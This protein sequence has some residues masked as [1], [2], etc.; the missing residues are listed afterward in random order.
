MYSDYKLAAFRVLNPVRRAKITA[1]ISLGIALLL[2]LGAFGDEVTIPNTPLPPD[3]LLEFDL[4]RDYLSGKLESWAR[5]LDRFFGDYR[6]YQESNESVIQFDFFRVM[7]YEDKP[8]FS[9]ATNIKVSLPNTE[10][11][12]QFLIETNPDT[13]TAAGPTKIQPQ[14]TVKKTTPES[15]SAALRYERIEAERWHFTTDGGIQLAG[16]N[17]TPFVRARL[18]LAMPLAQWNMKIADSVFWFSTIGAGESTLIDFERPIN[19]ALMFRASSNA[20]WLNDSQNFDL[21]QDMSFFH[22]LNERTA[23]LYQMSAIGMSNPQTQVSDY[24]ILMLYRYRLHREWMFI[25]ISPQMHYPIA[26]DFQPSPLLSLRL[27]ILFDHS[28]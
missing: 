14:P 10:K 1:C 22:A 4:P 23:V 9:Y 25:E 24:V 16:L 2:P 13:N 27:E 26:R 6:N 5:N 18:S 15:I 12:L 17:S 21:R 7:G 20:T 8:T 28:R 19:K 11:K 3:A